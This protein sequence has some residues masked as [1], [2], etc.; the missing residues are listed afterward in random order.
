MRFRR[1]DDDDFLTGTESQLQTS[2][3]RLFNPPKNRLLTNEQWWKKCMELDAQIRISIKEGR[4]PSR[5]KISN[6]VAD[7]LGFFLRFTVTREDYISQFQA[8]SDY[9]E[10]QE[11]QPDNVRARDYAEL[12]GLD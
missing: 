1:P 12:I 9:L 8:I 3:N 10:E 11:N 4:L 7:K 6:F 5:F 2:I